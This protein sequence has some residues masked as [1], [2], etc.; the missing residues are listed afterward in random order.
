MGSHSSSTGY[1]QNLGSPDSLINSHTR[2]GIN[3]EESALYNAPK[4]FFK[5]IN[6]N[7]DDI[8]E[9]LTRALK[10]AV[11]RITGSPPSATPAERSQWGLLAEILVTELL[12]A[13]GR[14]Q[15]ISSVPAFFAE[16]LR[17]R[18]SRPTA[19]STVR[20]N[21]NSTSAEPESPKS[22][23]QTPA[24]LNSEQIAQSAEMLAELLLRGE[25]TVASITN[26][27]SA[28][29][30]AEDWSAILDKAVQLEPERRGN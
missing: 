6:T 17:R 23:D 9:E 14:S 7:D 3:A 16:H 5:T 21:E 10:T 27:F 24:R 20:Q 29:F 8:F 2:P 11:I 12:E 18:F 1:A 19:G 15:M 30:H 22:E 4:T 13:A 28:G 26:Q 25:Y